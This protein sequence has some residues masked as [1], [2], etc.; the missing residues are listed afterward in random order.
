[1]SKPKKKVEKQSIRKHDLL[2]VEELDYVE[3][4]HVRIKN[5][6]ERLGLTQ[7]DLASMLNERLTVIKKIEQGEVRPTL[8]LARKIEKMLNIQIIEKAVIDEYY[9]PYISKPK[10]S[11]YTLGD[12]LKAIGEKEKQS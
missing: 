10:V 8:E 4:F 5:A 7:E 9:E 6:R 11:G 3:D 12:V 1:M 2:P